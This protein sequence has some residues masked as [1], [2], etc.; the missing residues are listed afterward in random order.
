MKK[1][2]YISNTIYYTGIPVFRNLINFFTLPILTR[3][4]TPADYGINSLVLM[5]VSFS[6]ILF[7]G[8]NTACNR[9]FF[10]H[11]D[12]PSALKRLFSTNVLALAGIAV[13]CFVGLWNLYPILNE[14]FF[15]NHL[16]RIWLLLAFFQFFLAYINI[17]NQYFFQNQFEG[18]KWFFNE[19]I[20]TLVLVPTTLILVMTRMFT[21]EAI[22][23][24]GLAAELVKCCIIFWQVRGYYALMFYPAIFKKSLQY[25]WPNIPT[26]AL[27]FGASYADRIFLSHF[28]GVFQVGIVDF[29]IRISAILKTALDGINGTL[30]PITVRLLNRNSSESFEKLANLNLKITYLALF[31]SFT[32]IVFTKALVL[33][34]ATPAYY[35]VIYIA[36]LYIFYHLFGILGMISYWQIYYKSK[37]TFWMIPINFLAC[38]SSLILNFLLIPYFGVIGAGVAAA[39]SALIVQVVQFGIGMRLTPIPLHIPKLISLFGTV[40]LGTGLLYG[41]YFFHFPF[42]IEILL[43]LGLLAIFIALGVLFKIVTMKEFGSVAELISNQLKEKFGRKL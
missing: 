27:G 40:I 43:Q 23:I 20:A 37:Y 11:T 26:T 9:F 1:V 2:R 33:I 29:S 14:Y 30:S 21:F 38:V 13:I 12:D 6:N 15:Q 25:S 36:P 24:A 22:I 28:S 7:L 8:I 41:V 5:I 19:L 35:P 39:G 42:Y 10:D 4:L 16:K 34:L 18:R 31:I 17:I 32:L 3:F